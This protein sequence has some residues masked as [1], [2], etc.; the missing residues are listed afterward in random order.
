M[1]FL[2]GAASGALV[3]GGVYYGFSAM[4]TTR[5]QHHQADLHRLSE[6][7]VN[8]AA[9]IPAPVPASQRIPDRTFVTA[10]QS[11]WNSQIETV[12]RGARQL[13][14]SIIEW[15]RKTLYGGDA[16]RTKPE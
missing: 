10:L 3:A 6:R 15:G 4:I 14:R 12:F 8:A 5:T 13:D 7:L 1:S 9:D 16:S 2:V 11:Q